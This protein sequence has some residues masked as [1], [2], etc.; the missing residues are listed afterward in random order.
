M[1]FLD[2]LKFYNA[3]WEWEWEWVFNEKLAKSFGRFKKLLLKLIN[4][5][6]IQKQSE[7]IS[8]GFCRHE[9]IPMKKVNLDY[10]WAYQC[11]LRICKWSVGLLRI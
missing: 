9:S 11:Q 8:N 10:I 1:L 6:L 3:E 7:K 4:G 2:Q 5:T